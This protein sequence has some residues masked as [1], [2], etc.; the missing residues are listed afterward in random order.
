MSKNRQPVKKI[1]VTIQSK[2]GWMSEKDAKEVEKGIANYLRQFDQSLNWN[3]K[4][5]KG[6]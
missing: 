4:L 2:W 1:D 6:A 5:R 3:I